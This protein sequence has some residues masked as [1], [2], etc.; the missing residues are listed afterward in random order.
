MK[1]EKNA[2][3]LVIDC[4]FVQIYYL[5]CFLL[6]SNLLCLLLLKKAL[7][8][9]ILYKFFWAGS[10]SAFFKQLDPDPHLSSWIRIRI[11]KNCWIRISKNWMW[12]HSPD[13]YFC[14]KIFKYFC[15]NRQ[16][17]SAMVSMW[18]KTWLRVVQHAQQRWCF[19]ITFW[20]GSNIWYPW[21]WTPGLLSWPPNSE[22]SLISL[23]EWVFNTEVRERERSFRCDSQWKGCGSKKLYSLPVLWSWSNLDPAPDIKKI[24]NLNKKYSL[25]V[26]K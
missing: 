8:K 13:L 17:L 14:S 7:H 20:F 11:Q 9:V 18:K 23:D 25:Q 6:L 21:I 22:D 19:N 2:R 12:I 3:K 16:K 24:D 10:G 15:K 1:T 26:E 4:K 5:H